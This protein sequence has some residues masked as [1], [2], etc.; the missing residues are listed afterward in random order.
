[1]S[2]AADTSPPKAGSLWLNLSPGERRAVIG[3]T[4]ALIIWYTLPLDGSVFGFYWSSWT[5]KDSYYV[6]G[7]AVPLISGWFIWRKRQV[8]ATMAPQANYW[9]IL[10]IAAATVLKVLGDITRLYSIAGFTTP[11]LV[12]GL[13]WLL[14]GTKILRSVWFPIAFLFFA[15]PLFQSII[16][17]VSFPLQLWSSVIGAKILDVMGEVQRVGVQLTFNGEAVEVAAPCSGFRL[18]ITML[19]ASV[20]FAYMIRGDLWR[21]LILVAAS[22]PLALLMNS[23]RVVTLAATNTWLGR[24]AMEAIHEPSGWV[25]FGLSCLVFWLGMRALGCREYNEN[26]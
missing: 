13:V 24:D 16:T 3:L 14:F 11:I 8:L 4:V 22:M 17:R 7:P 1:M 19:M 26:V 2:T 9:G 20:V 25:F 15:C 23:L 6:H 21:K 10:P 12:G 5:K 18:T